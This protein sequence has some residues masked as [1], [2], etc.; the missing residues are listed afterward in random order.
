MTTT[1]ASPAEGTTPDQVRDARVLIVGAGVS[2]MTAAIALQKAGV[3]DDEVLIV[4]AGDEVGGTWRDNTYPGCACDVP[5][6]LYSFSFAQNPDWSR[7]FARQPEIQEYVRGVAKRFGL[8]RRVEFGVRAGAGRWDDDAQRW[9]VETSAGTVRAQFVV[10]AAGPLYEPKLP[11][12]D[13]IERFA[14]DIF[15]SSRWDHSVSLEG[16]NVVVVGTGASAIQLVPK[17]QPIVGKLTLLQRTPSWVLPR[18]DRKIPKIERWLYRRV[19]GL[20]NFVRQCFRVVLEGQQLGQRH[21]RVMQ[22]AQKLGL[23]NLRRQVKDPVLRKALTPQFT[24]GCKRLMMSNT[25]YPALVAPNAT[26]VPHALTEIRERSIVAAD[27]T[28]HPADVIV[29][30]TGFHVTDPPIAG[31]VKGRSGNSLSDSWGESPQ[32]YLGTVAPDVPN[33]FLMVGPN[34]GNGHTSIFLP[35]E[36]QAKW[37]AQAVTTAQ[38]EGIEALEVKW[39]VH[40]RWNAAVQAGLR[41]TVWNAGGCASYYLDAS[42]RNSTIYP[43]TTYDLDRRMKRFDL[44]DFNTSRAGEHLPELP[45]R[46]PATVG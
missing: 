5:S 37:I 41:N 1:D 35:V 36:A 20:Q 4:D 3:R 28:E 10:A 25:Y 21:P 13:G 29:F 39:D 8:D 43:W 11:E 38:R 17:I 6:I 7:Q 32:A 27:G 19:P 2:G 31:Q 16:K 15:H 34:L 22:Q 30:A 42:G 26:V 9:I 24:L 18:P 33:S 12:V 46:L 23:W 44:A 45:V 40:Q 14:G